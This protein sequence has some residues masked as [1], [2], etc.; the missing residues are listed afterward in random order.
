MTQ[1][2]NTKK[3]AEAIFG[4]ITAEKEIKPIQEVDSLEGYDLSFVGF[5]IVRFGPGENVKQF[6]TQHSAGKKIALFATHSS[7][8]ENPLVQQWLT[9]AQEATSKGELVGLFNCRGALSP[10]VK[11]VMLQHEDPQLRAW[12]EHDDSEGQ[13]DET[14]LERARAFAQQ[15]M[16]RLA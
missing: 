3:I 11:A 1:T 13:P 5:P 14:R 2:G 12:A 8:E 15:I 6:L 9:P 16:G 10:Q 4:E 7:P